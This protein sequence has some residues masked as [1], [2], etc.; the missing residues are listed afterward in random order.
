MDVI[1]IPYMLDLELFL[2]TG[3]PPLSHVWCFFLPEKK[4]G[5]RRSVS[6][7]SERRLEIKPN[8]C[9]GAYLSWEER[10]TAE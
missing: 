7:L 3:F 2:S 6:S 4:G 10:G 1:L 9:H 8:F 5:R